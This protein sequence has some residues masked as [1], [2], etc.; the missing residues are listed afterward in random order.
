[1]N[2][3]LLALQFLTT[4]P[5][6]VKYV[7]EKKLAN[8]LIYFPV[9]GLLLGLILVGLNQLLFILNFKEFISG[10]ILVISLIIIT[11]GI[12]L[13]GLSDTFDALLSEKD[14]DKMLEIMRDPHI[15]VM[16][17]LSII[18]VLLLKIS[19][20]SSIPSSLK[21]VSLVLMCLLSRWALV[22][23]MFLFPYARQDGKAKI[24]MQNI[25]FKI[26]SLATIITLV[27]IVLAWRLNGLLIFAIVAICAY[28]MG[29][30][31]K[32]KI[33]GITGDTLGAINELVEIIVLFS[34][35]IIA[36]I[37]LWII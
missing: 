10:I 2:I 8:S 30:F 3:F 31:I 15:G 16:G 13:D 22:F 27:F 4:I 24:F 34:I 19:F 35:N 5:L 9:V 26:F 25:N 33:N 36:R 20:L 1:M 6:K 21:P 29:R 7:D 12:H 18:G 11:G 28:V 37:S 32:G 23:S 17:A 14:K